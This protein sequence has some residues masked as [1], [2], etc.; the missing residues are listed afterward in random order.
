MLAHYLSI[1]SQF[2][3]CFNVFAYWSNKSFELIPFLYQ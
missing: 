1:L 2:L 3:S